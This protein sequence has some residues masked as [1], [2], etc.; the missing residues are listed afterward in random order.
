EVG[1]HQLAGDQFAA[2]ELREPELPR[3]EARLSQHATAGPHHE[4]VGAAEVRLIQQAARKLRSIEPSA[5]ERC[6]AKSHV[7]EAR[8]PEAHLVERG[9]AEIA[10]SYEAAREAVLAASTREHLVSARQY[11]PVFVFRHA[12]ST[13][14]HF[15][16]DGN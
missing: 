16:V 13:G 9:P 8:V 12:G 3:F 1:T 10:P 11:R 14:V 5:D 4:P 2:I 15:A 6:P 7:L